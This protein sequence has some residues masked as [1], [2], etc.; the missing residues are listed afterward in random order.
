MRE[1]TADLSKISAERLRDELF[2]ILTIKHPDASLRIL[3]TLNALDYLLP[4]VCLLK[5]VQQ[6][7]PHVMDAWNH[8]LDVL[9]RL[10]NLLDVLRTEYNPDK[11][12][13][14]IMGLL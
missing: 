3:D 14:L 10:E 4:E 6:S 8:T 1:A 13:N 12:D 7:K 9:S 5:D 2:K 11:A